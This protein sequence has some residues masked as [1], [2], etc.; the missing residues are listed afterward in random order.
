MKSISPELAAH[1]AS[2]TPTLAWIWRVTRTDDSV[3][4][5]TTASDDLEFD[6]VAYDAATGF[7]GHDIETAEDLSVSNSEVAGVLDS[8]T[9]TAADIHAGLWDRSK[10]DIEIVNYRDLTMGSIWVG[11]GVVGQI[12][13]GRL[14]FVAELRGL[15]QLLGQTV[16][17]AAEKR[18]N[19]MLGDA[20]CGVDLGPLTDTGTLTAVNG[21][22]LTDS[23]NAAVS[24]WYG[25]GLLTM[26]SGD[27][28]GITIE[29]ITF[30]SGV[31]TLSVPL[32]FGAQVG[33]TYSAV[34]GCRKRYQED[35]IT[36][37]DNV[38]NF[39]GFPFIPGEDKIRQVGGRNRA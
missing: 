37:H 14:R 12:R 2:E 6:D 7:L 13:P 20:R 5:F 31:F 34:P 15:T 26:T 25:A 3:Y 36:K 27:S 11:G 1:L 21:R 10:M 33:D 17:R 16:G 18:C 32:P 35:C 39:R 23:G 30:A 19:A 9:I 28:T 22:V 24:D 4:G 8:S 29:V 38:I